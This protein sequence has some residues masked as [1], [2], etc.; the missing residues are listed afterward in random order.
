MKHPDYT[1]DETAL[2]D[3]A[4]GWLKFVDNGYL[5]K[6]EQTDN[7]YEEQRWSELTDL[8]WASIALPE[9]VGGA[10]GTLAQVGVA[11]RECGRAGY[12][13][14]LLSTARAVTLLDLVQGRDTVFDGVLRGVVAGNALALVAP[15]D[16]QL[17]VRPDGDG[18]LLEGRASTVEWLAQA[19]SAVFAV[20]VAN[21]DEVLVAVLQTGGLDITPVPSIDNE[22]QATLTPGARVGADVPAVVVPAAAAARA[23][24]R[25]DLLRASSMVGG[26]EAVL[27]LTAKYAL[28]RHQFG[29][30]IGAFQ[31]VRQHLG[32]MSMALDAARLS[33]NEALS[34]E[35]ESPARPA[36]M[37]AVALFV[38]GRSYV[39]VALTAAQ[40]HG[41]IG[42]TV[43]HVLHHHYRRAK[44]MQLRSGRPANRLREIH[45]SLVVRGDGGLW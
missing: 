30:P 38:A 41:G 25:A 24:G 37:D 15:P 11:L 36:A 6:Q 12:A 8:G 7:G 43:D 19:D 31:A 3:S 16:G 28:E 9:R 17:G 13:T 4:E 14:P 5:N 22:L 29:Q 21:T 1:D 34:L 23:L 18:Y 20:P 40:L 39:E 32:R 10:A 33:T 26:C 42:T 27:D 2:A 35:P 45:R 44:G